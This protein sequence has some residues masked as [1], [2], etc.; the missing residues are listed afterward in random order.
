MSRESVIKIYSYIYI[1]LISL[2]SF[3]YCLAQKTDFYRITSDDGLQNNIVFSVVQDNKGFMWF[4][5]ITGIDRYDGSN[6]VHYRLPATKSKSNE[7]TQVNNIISDNQQR[8][9]ASTSSSVFLYNSILDKFDTVSIFQEKTAVNR[10]I[11]F[12][13]PDKR[14]GIWIGTNLG[15]IFIDVENNNLLESKYLKLPVRSMFQ[16]SSGTLWAGTNKGLYKLIHKKQEIESQKISINNFDSTVISS[17]S[18]DNHNRIWIGTVDKGLFVMNKQNF[19]VNRVR[20]PH[21]TT[22]YFTVKDIFHPQDKNETY[23]ALDGG[24]V[25]RVDENLKIKFIDQVNDDDP[26]SLSNNGV[27]DIY[28]DYYNRIWVATYGGGVNVIYNRTQKFLNL[29]HEINNPN[30]L[31]N[32]MAK[33]VVEDK[34]GNI[35]FGTRKGISKYNSTTKSW[36]QINQDT[37]KYSFTTDIVLGLASADNGNIWAATYGGG[38]VCYSQE[39][40]TVK[41]YVNNTSDSESVG[42]DYVYAICVDKNQRIW[43]GGI[44]GPLSMLNT[45]TGKFK[46]FNIGANGVNC[47][48]QDTYGDMIIGTDRGILFINKKNEI[49]QL[50]GEVKSGSHAIEKVISIMEYNPGEFWIGTQGGG[51]IIW[52]KKSGFRKKI[53]V[54][55]GLPSDIVCGMLKDDNGDVWISTT[56]G[57]VHY[58][59][60]NR[61]FIYYTKG[62][63]LAGS[64]FNYNAFCKLKDGNMIFGGT[65]GF[66]LFNPSSIKS[67]GIKPVLHFTGLS[68]NNKRSDVGSNDEALYKSI[69]EITRLELLFSQNSFSVDFV[70]PTPQT[71][72]KHLYSWKLEG[73]DKDW[74]PLS[75]SN[76]A[77]YT[78]LNAGYYKLLVKALAKGSLNDFSEIRSLEI[79]IKSPWWRT[80]W[81]YF[82]YL[83]MLTGVSYLIYNYNTT[84]RA[85]ERF[86]ER[87]E[88]HTAIAHELRTP[89]TLIKAPI[90]SL[91]N[92]D[93]LKEEDKENLELAKKNIS[94]LENLVSQFIDYHKSGLNK[95]ILNLDRFDVIELLDE[96][97]SLYVPL[98]KDKQIRLLYAPSVMNLQL[99]ADRD[100]LDKVF[101]NLLSNAIKYTPNNGAVTIEVNISGDKVHFVFSDTGIGIPEDQQGFIF[102]GFYRADNAINLKEVGSG[103]GLSIVQDMIALHKGLVYFNSIANKGSTFKVELPIKNSNL[104]QQFILAKQLP[105]DKLK[106][107]LSS[108]NP[109]PKSNRIMVV[110][111]NDELREYIVKELTFKG[112]KVFDA[113]NGKEALAIAQKISLGLIISDLMMPEMNG[114]EL[115]LAIKKS[116]NTSHLPFILLTSLHDKEYIIQGLSSGADEFVSKPFDMDVLV[117]KAES[118]LQN[119]VLFK[120]KLMSAFKKVEEMEAVAVEDQD[121]ELLRKVAEIV[122]SK[123][124]EHDFNVEKLSIL[125]AMSR[126]ALFK[127]FKI[128]TG[129]SLQ[130]YINAIRFKKAVELLYQSKY[131]ITE[132]AYQVG[133]E[134]SKYFSTAFKKFY[135]LTPSEYL[136]S[137]KT[138]V[139]QSNG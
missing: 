59:I 100:K 95:Q 33:A 2:N 9:W 132:V 115:C 19:I 99:L 110:E 21:L 92:G 63:G 71:S 47:I 37:Y 36:Q 82:A 62:D 137:I 136:K 75:A 131:N 73:F 28:K 55:D 116:I 56:N 67:N 113:S 29:R 50:T 105:N 139:S 44:R 57:L 91:K 104:E 72:G 34:F 32:N 98:A 39:S 31:S 134:D 88:L 51:L 89:L 3:K 23:V 65:N 41:T 12:L 6:F 13:I 16:D 17:I 42:T 20:I 80:W 77:I 7:F 27:Y 64:Q 24:G 135:G 45:K 85:R 93:H 112:Y 4:A 123:Y 74:T 102:S 14:K 30:S 70:S 5:T 86:A 15:V 84:R 83:C 129:Q 26:T 69:D 10:I 18:I 60:V 68:I 122:S 87:L 35:W 53:T 25:A 66:S 119:R 108:S 109:M 125:M 101:S 78:N 90:A 120:Q 54:Y 22:R 40:K 126:P 52:N 46:R 97:V 138:D 124:N 96:I 1:L 38:I 114:F 81:A 128:I 118:L 94:K 121:I 106:P 11:Y 43:S 79:Y 130:E 58:Q 107:D 111:D 117:A 49:I 61:M 127:K 48:I 8:I 133:F 103:V 76:T